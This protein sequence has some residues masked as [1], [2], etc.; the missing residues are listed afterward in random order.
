MFV[1][2]TLDA[3]PN[4]VYQMHRLPGVQRD[5]SLENIYCS[6]G[7]SNAGPTPLPGAPD[8]LTPDQAGDQIG[9]YAYVTFASGVDYDTA[10]YEVSNLGLR[11]ADPCYEYALLANRQPEQWHPMGQEVTFSYAHTLVVAPAPLIS[12]VMWREQLRKLPDVTTV[13]ASYH[14][15]C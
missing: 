12:A 5:P 9:T 1:M 6:G 8:V 3:A 10:L 2:R 4:W 15:A 14:P 11:L 13:D 7:H